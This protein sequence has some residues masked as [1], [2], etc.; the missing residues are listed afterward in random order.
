MR[1]PARRIAPGRGEGLALVRRS[2]FSFIGGVDPATGAL[3]NGV[4]G[5]PE[6]RLE[7]RVFAFPT[8]KGSTVGSYVIYGLAK[9]GLGPTALVN[10]RAEAIT[11]VGA[12]LGGIPSVDHVDL[13]ALVT[14]DRVVVDADAGEVL[15]PD[16]TE[17]HVVS[18]FL[19]NRGRFLVVRRSEKVG[20]FQGRWSAISGYMEGEEDPRERARREI[21]EETGIRSPRF[22]A[23][24]EPVVARHG[25]TAF[26]VHPFLFDVPSRRVILDWENVEHRW[27]RPED[28][29]DLETVPRLKDVLLSALRGRRATRE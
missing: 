29:D 11:A 13:G 19:R 26:V 5:G 8:G 9:R 6:E 1:I 10:E 15:L 4:L 25:T 3:T 23:A 14:G 24:G 27:V 18:A 28:L 20:T 21:R 22:R 17:R 2:P 16:V 12:I 7:G